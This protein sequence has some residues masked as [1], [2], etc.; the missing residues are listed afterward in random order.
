MRRRSS[1]ICSCGISRWKGRISVAAS[2]V[3]L[4]C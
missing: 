3:V 1:S 4:M 2:T